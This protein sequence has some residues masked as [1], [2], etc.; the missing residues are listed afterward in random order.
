MLPDNREFRMI[1]VTEKG[2][3]VILKDLDSNPENITFATDTYYA[4]ALVYKDI[5]VVK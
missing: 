2:V 4:F 1:C 3:P 5:V